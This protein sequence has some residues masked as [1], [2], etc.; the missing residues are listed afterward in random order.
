MRRWKK[1][2]CSGL[3]LFFVG[4]G[5]LG[6][7][8][9]V[10][11]TT[12]F[13]LLALWLFTKSSDRLRHW[14]LTNRVFGKYLRDYKSGRGI[15]L[16]SKIYIL[17][18]LWAAITISALWAVDVMWIKILLFAIAGGV[19]VHIFHIR[20]KPRRPRIVVLVP[21]EG[22]CRYFKGVVSDDVEVRISGVGMAATASAAALALARRPDVMILAGIAGAYPGSGLKVGD[23]V[24]VSSERVADQ[25]AFREEGFV[26][27]YVS[28]YECPYVEDRLVMPS[29]AGCT[30]N[31]A[32]AGYVARAGALENMEGAAFFAVCA[33]A[34]VEFLEVRS[35]SNMTDDKRADWKLDE[36]C[37]ALAEGVKKLTDEI[38]S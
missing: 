1:R 29:V 32:G 10:L 6:V 26:P 38:R 34:G 2:L 12:P 21:T 5:I 23:C 18:L 37:R 7:V 4:L 8:L 13:L 35:I 11:P 9:P 15:P 16:Q 25:G 31:A 33:G 22:E 24:L 36:A 20:T 27:L 30:V 19:T 3:G 14:L 17:V 28:E